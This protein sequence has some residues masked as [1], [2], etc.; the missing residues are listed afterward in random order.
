MCR[1]L[2]IYMQLQRVPTLT[3]I[4][5]G[6]NSDTVRL[7]EHTNYHYLA[8]IRS[9]TPNPTMTYPESQLDV[10]QREPCSFAQQL[11]HFQYCLVPNGLQGQ[12]STLGHLQYIRYS[13][14]E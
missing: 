10:V 4:H 2:A 8:S 12:V 1:G 5:A 11:P 6:S 14:N 13:E 7:H 3:D 9:P